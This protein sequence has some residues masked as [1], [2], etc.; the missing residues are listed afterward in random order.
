MTE[1]SLPMVSVVAPCRNEVRFIENILNSILQG[2]YPADRMELLVVDGMST[3]GTR[4]IIQKMAAQNNH[5]KL[6]DNPGKIQATAMNIG[7][8]AARGEYI[9]RVDCHAVYPADYI[10]KCVEL[11]ERTG[12]ANAGGYWDTLPGADTAKAGAI[13][14]ATSSRFG[15]GNSVY[16][17]GG[18]KQEQECD[19][20]AAGTFRREIFEK[21]GL[22][23]ERLV[24]NEDTE[25]NYRIRKSGGLI[26]I[27]S[28]IKVGYY[29]RATYRGLFQQ[30][31]N[32]GL[33]NLYSIWLTG[34]RLFVRH[35]IPLFFVLGLIILATGT[36]FW[37]PVKWLLF[38][39][40]LLY[41]SVAAVSSIK[42][43]RRTKVSPVSVLWAYIV[44]HIGYGLG[45]LWGVITI[46]FK[47]PDRHKKSIGKAS[48]D[49][50]A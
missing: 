48:A 47:F 23:D 7:I 20:A 6:L 33:W 26:I 9:A 13:A 22:Y 10:H 38:G 43:T 4:Q 25:L 18:S 45:S 11:A 34:V 50:I 3:D 37:W 29:N 14:A 8:K 1:D 19:A 28:E 42:I 17:I 12:A 24:R 15:V 5:I 35:F 30:A 40:T 44:L 31:F 36:F 32:N 21:I 41:L 2:D 39:Y 27:S 49:R 46:P 16:R